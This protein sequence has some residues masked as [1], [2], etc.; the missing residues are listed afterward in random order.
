MSVN[1]NWK[2]SEQT[3]AN[4]LLV[5]WNYGKETSNQVSLQDYE[6][7]GSLK[8]Y[9]WQTLFF[10]LRSTGSW[11]MIL[12]HWCLVTPYGDMIWVNLGSGNGLLPDG[13]KPLPEPKLTFHWGWSAAFTWE[14]FHKK[15]SWKEI[16]IL[17]LFPCFPGANELIKV[18][19][20][21]Y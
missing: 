15:C 18:S 5:L 19:S 20:L 8:C 2:F 4:G 10:G 3:K 14:Q 6:F 21:D 12:N 16:M 9:I 17:K 11:S 1:L 7:T 13:T